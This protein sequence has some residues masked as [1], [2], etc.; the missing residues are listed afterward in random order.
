MNEDDLISPEAKIKNSIAFLS[1]RVSQIEMSEK[2]GKFMEEIA[3]E[4][5]ISHGVVVKTI[6][7]YL[8]FCL[9]NGVGEK[10]ATKLMQDEINMGLLSFRELKEE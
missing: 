3:N 8:T 7:Q 1:D 9:C 4:Y 10:L 2:M 6:L 5:G